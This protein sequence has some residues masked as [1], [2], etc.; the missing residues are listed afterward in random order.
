MMMKCEVMLMFVVVKLLGNQCK[1]PVLLFECLIAWMSVLCGSSWLIFEMII[2]SSSA[3]MK[4]KSVMTTENHKNSINCSLCVCRPCVFI[5]RAHI[6]LFGSF[7][8]SCLNFHCLHDVVII[9]CCVKILFF[10]FCFLKYD[11]FPESC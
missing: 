7:V 9:E 11:I 2:T 5:S 1:F 8:R 10:S 4:Y 6:F 3:N